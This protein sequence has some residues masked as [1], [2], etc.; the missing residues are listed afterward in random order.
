MNI[1]RKT[2][3]KTVIVLAILGLINSGY[4]SILYITENSTVC[5]I[6]ATFS[7]SSVRM[8]EYSPLLGI[9]VPIIG[10]IG[11]LILLFGAVIMMNNNRTEIFKK[12]INAKNMLIISLA[13]LSYSLFLTYAEFAIIKAWCLFC[14]ISQ[15]I[16][17]VLT[18]CYY[19]IY[20]SHA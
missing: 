10:F 7:C 4:L 6:N 5:D 16:M 14:I 19:R 20:K 12:Y 13:G 15:I 9:P 11:N 3:I 18:A 17:I 8:S 1:S 2:L